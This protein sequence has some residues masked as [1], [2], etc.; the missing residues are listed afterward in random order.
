MSEVYFGGFEMKRFNFI[1]FYD[2]MSID[3]D[4]LSTELGLPLTVRVRENATP[5]SEERM[6][7]MHDRVTI[8]LLRHALRDDVKFYEALR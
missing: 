4:R 3:L 5:G 6:N 1:G 7:V 8:D 2:N